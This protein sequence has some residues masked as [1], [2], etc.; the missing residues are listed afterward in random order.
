MYFPPLLECETLRNEINTSYLQ[1]LE[2]VII[3]PGILK[4]K[5]VLG[6]LIVL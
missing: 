3:I 6:I 1:E 5:L 4:F 2:D